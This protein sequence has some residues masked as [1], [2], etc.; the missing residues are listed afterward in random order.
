MQDNTKSDKILHKNLDKIIIG[1]YY[2]KCEIT[3]YWQ[4]L[5]DN[6]MKDFKYK[7]TKIQYKVS[8]TLHKTLKHKMLLNPSL[9][10]HTYMHT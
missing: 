2:M 8:K 1:N 5:P 10:Y 9:T 7:N 3:C 6:K 4:I